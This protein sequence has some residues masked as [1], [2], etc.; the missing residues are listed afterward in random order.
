MSG[1]GFTIT[2]G[3]AAIVLTIVV[4]LAVFSREAKIRR[5]LHRTRLRSIA[6]FPDGGEARVV[7]RLSY[8]GE[9]ITAP[10]S[11]RECAL[12]HAVVNA[13]YSSDGSGSW[14]SV[15]DV[16]IGVDWMLSDGT[17]HAVVRIGPME[18]IVFKDKHYRSGIFND[19]TPSLERFLASHGESSTTV[20]GLNR[21]IHYREG[22]LA[23]GEEVTVSGVGRWMDLPVR[24]LH[25]ELRNAKGTV[26]VLV[27]AGTVERPLLI[28]DEVDTVKGTFNLLRTVR[29]WRGV[30]VN[31]GYDLR[32][33][34]SVGCPECGWQK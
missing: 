17:G 8:I 21:A 12:Y 2:I 25:P 31:C 28:S 11:Q 19:A 20:S 18:T 16:T 23:Y 32:G 29:R 9:A 13:K 1:T 30:C 10:F 26:R 15:I 22:I 6:R 24:E 4:V 27:F 3:C 7:G 5:R 14:R 34:R 33:Q